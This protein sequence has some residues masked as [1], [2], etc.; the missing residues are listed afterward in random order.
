MF[1]QYY[2][3]RLHDGANNEVLIFSL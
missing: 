3:Q 2:A 1:Y